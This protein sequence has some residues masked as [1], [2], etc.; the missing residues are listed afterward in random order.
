MTKDDKGQVHLKGYLIL[1]RVLRTL[2]YMIIALRVLG[3]NH[4]D[5]ETKMVGSKLRRTKP[6]LG[7]GNL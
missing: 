4:P 5:S 6:L 1:R 7:L 2:L 3:T